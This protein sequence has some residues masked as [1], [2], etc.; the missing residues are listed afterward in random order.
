M[1]SWALEISGRIRQIDLDSGECTIRNGESE[2]KVILDP[3]L[4]S[5]AKRLFRDEVMV[6]AVGFY[7]SG[8][9]FAVGELRE[10]S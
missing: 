9:V 6:V 7:I 10:V 2:W 3:A 5:R 1:D 4:E 8:R